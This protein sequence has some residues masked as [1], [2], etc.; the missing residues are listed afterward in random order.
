MMCAM[1]IYLV[2]RIVIATPKKWYM[3]LLRLVLGVVIALLG[4]STVDLII[5]EREISEQLQVDAKQ[6][7]AV[8]FEQKSASVKIA[9]DQKKSDWQRAL[10]AANCEANGT[11]GSRL[12]SVGPVYRELSRQAETLR[13]D[14]LTEQQKFE[15]LNNKKLE[16]L[17]KASNLEQVSVNAGLLSR[18]SALHEYTAKNSAAL[19]A[20]I[21]FLS[22]VIFFELM[23]VIAKF[24]FDETVDDELDQI[25]EF[26]SQD[27]ARAYKE[28]VTSPMYN[29]RELVYSTLN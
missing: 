1:S 15:L 28:T 13:K 16:D 27:R 24:V 5:F 23:V 12:R 3:S 14:Y 11:C 8:D 17:E 18:I 10:E 20:W 4:S 2:E 19:I 29:A 7:I 9:L 26:I 6:R 21:L 25:R 22:L